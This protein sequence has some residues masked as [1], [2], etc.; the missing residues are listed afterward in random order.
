MFEKW[1]ERVQFKSQ[2]HHTDQGNSDVFLGEK[3]LPPPQG[4]SQSHHT[5][6]GNSDVTKGN[7]EH[8]HA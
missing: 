2:S 5:D 1:G 3:E 8:E 7:N 6:Q 4:S